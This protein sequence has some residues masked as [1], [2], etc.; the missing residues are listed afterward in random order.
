MRSVKSRGG[1]TNGRGM[2]ESVRLVWLHSILSGIVACASNGINC[3]EVEEIGQKIM[4]SM[5]NSTCNEIK[6]KKAE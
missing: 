2:S 1:L 3:D 4:T 5:D 6:H